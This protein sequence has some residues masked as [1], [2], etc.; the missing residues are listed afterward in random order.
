MVNRYS[1]VVSHNTYMTMMTKYCGNFAA[2]ITEIL[3][4]LR[5]SYPGNSLRKIQSSL[6]NIIFHA[7]L[8]KYSDSAHLFKKWKFFSI[9]SVS[10]YFDLKVQ[11]MS[12][13]LHFMVDCSL[14]NCWNWVWEYHIGTYAE[15]Q[16]QS[17]YRYSLKFVLT[18]LKMSAKHTLKW[19]FRYNFCE[20]R[21]TVYTALDGKKKWYQLCVGVPDSQPSSLFGGDLGLSFP[22]LS[23]PPLVAASAL[24]GSCELF[25]LTIHC[26]AFSTAVGRLVW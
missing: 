6:F 13:W 5:E 24:S 20:S 16:Q 21:K 14:I 8:I 4:G 1:T 26:D 15:C 19:Q 22:L 17:D 10:K 2:K 3:S 9:L 12:K 7:N 18:F 23:L 25:P 11:D